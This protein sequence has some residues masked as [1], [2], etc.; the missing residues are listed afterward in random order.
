MSYYGTLPADESGQRAPAL[1]GNY[2]SSINCAIS[3]LTA[4]LTGVVYVIVFP[5]IVNSDLD[6]VDAFSL[7]IITASGVPTF[8]LVILIVVT[9]PC[10]SRSKD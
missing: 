7:A 5:R 1:D 10:S 2:L 3:L 9:W 6:F 8:F 4:I